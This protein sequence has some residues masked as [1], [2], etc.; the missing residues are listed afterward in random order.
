VLGEVDDMAVRFQN[1]EPVDVAA[2][3]ADAVDSRRGRG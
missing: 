1:P 2:P 3:V